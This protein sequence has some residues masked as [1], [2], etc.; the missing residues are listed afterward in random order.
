MTFT[1]TL[2]IDLIEHEGYRRSAY[3]DHLGFLTIGIGRMIDEKKGGGLTMD[4]SR[5]LLRNDIENCINQLNHALPWF[6]NSPQ[7]VKRAL[8][9]MTFQMGIEGV[10]MFKNTLTLL[11][12]K[13]YKE[14]ADNALKSKWAKQ[15]PK[16]AAIVTGWIRD[17]R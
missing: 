12:K 10:L 7:S 13:K 8:V 9:N 3:K 6:N 14:A 16:R 17:A 4:E 15:T 1:E 2:E 11:E 5:Y